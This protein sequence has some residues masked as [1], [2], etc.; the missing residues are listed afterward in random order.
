M[1]LSTPPPGPGA[2]ARVVPGG[3]VGG[4]PAQGLCRCSPSQV[5]PR[6]LSSC[7]AP[8][9]HP[10]QQGTHRSS[11]GQRGVFFLSRDLLSLPWHFAG[12]SRGRA[13]SL[14]FIHHVTFSLW[15]H[16]LSISPIFLSPVPCRV[17]N[18]LLPQTHGL[19][20]SILSPRGLRRSGTVHVERPR[21][22]LPRPSF[23]H[24]GQERVCGCEFGDRP[25]PW[26]SDY[27]AA[28]SVS[29]CSGSH[30]SGSPSAHC[31]KATGSL[32]T[33]K[34]YIVSHSSGPPVPGSMSKAYHR[35]GAVSKYV[36]GWKK[37]EGSPP[38]EEPEVT[39]CQG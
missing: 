22:C 30:H 27:A 23:T 12:D 8:P 10:R 5:S 34:V 19:P 31:S 38:P 18:I 25:A 13:P 15:E 32:D 16:R 26:S 17:F 29:L 28:L 37:S 35:Q 2:R 1:P 20:W 9:T 24:R 21:L 4:L 33:S 14:T 36:I 7:H 11:P 39:E 3:H 6:L